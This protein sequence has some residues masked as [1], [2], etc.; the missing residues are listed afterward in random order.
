MPFGCV[1]FEAL[2]DGQPE[3]IVRRLCLQCLSAVWPLRP[4]DCGM[5]TINSHLMSPM[6]FGCVAFEAPKPRSSQRK[7]PRS[8]SPMP[9]GCVAF[10]A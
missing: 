4:M 3:A 10:E 9:F 2:P 1:A 7:P 6:P 5:I 8:Q